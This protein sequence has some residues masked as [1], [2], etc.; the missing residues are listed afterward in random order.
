MIMFNLFASLAI[1][2]AALTATAAHAQDLSK[3]PDWSGQWK[4]PAGVGNN[5]DFGKPAGR[6]QQAP[7]TPEY[8]AIFDANSADRA[9]GGLGGD[10]T[11]LCLPHG[12]PRMMIAVYPIELI[13]TPATVYILTDYTT[14]RRIFTDGRPWPKEIL[15][16]FN[17]YSIGRWSDTDGDGV[18]DLLEVETRGF[19]APRTFEGSGLLLHDDGQTVIKERLQLDP[20]NKDILRNE[21]T[22]I[23]NALTRPWTVTRSYRRDRNPTWDFVDCAEHNPHVRVG[24]ESY[25]VS[26]DGYLMPTKVGQAPPDPRYFN[27]K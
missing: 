19:K 10:P 11:G 13:V 1:A 21:T 27:R 9:E 25:M 20:A 5:F 3:Y 4:K 6:G 15:P 24:K 7:L 23:D 16:S 18:Y 8:Q 17:G 2:A 12:M 14:H 22:V 26:A